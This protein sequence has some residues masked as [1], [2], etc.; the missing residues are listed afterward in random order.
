MVPIVLVAAVAIAGVA[1]LLLERAPSTMKMERVEVA[2]GKGF[3]IAPPPDYLLI[4]DSRAAVPEGGIA[5]GRENEAGR[6]TIVVVPYPVEHDELVTEQGC[7]TVA[8]LHAK[9]V[10]AQLVA[11]KLV[12]RDSGSSCTASLSEGPSAVGTMVLQPI[13]K[14]TVMLTCRHPRDSVRDADAC[15]AVAKAL[16]TP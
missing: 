15:D 5:L 3:S 1:L 8:K 11:S 6:A 4:V 14:D 2:E 10:G 12:V 16:R 9:Q 7:Q 13:G